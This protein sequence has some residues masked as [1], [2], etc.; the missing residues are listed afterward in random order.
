MPPTQ[1]PVDLPAYVGIARTAAEPKV[2]RLTHQRGWHVHTSCGLRINV[3]SILD[4]PKFTYEGI[5]G[6]D[7]EQPLMRACK[8][9]ARTPEPDTP[10]SMD[11]E[12][13]QP[14][15][16]PPF[17][18]HYMG[19]K[20]HG[21]PEKISGMAGL[22]DVLIPEAR[23]LAVI[24]VVAGKEKVSAYLSGFTGNDSRHP[25]WPHWIDGSHTLVLQST[26][27]GRLGYAVDAVTG[28]F[29]DGTPAP[30]L[31]IPE[32]MT[33]P[34]DGG[35][36]DM[37]SWLAQVSQHMFDEASTRK[38]EYVITR[39]YGSYADESTSPVAVVESK[40]VAKTMVRFLDHAYK[41]FEED[42]GIDDVRF[43]WKEAERLS[44]SPYFFSGGDLRLRLTDPRVEEVAEWAFGLTH[45]EDQ[46]ETAL[47]AYKESGY[48][49]AEGDSN[50]KE[51][52]PVQDF[53]RQA[54]EGSLAPEGY[55]KPAKDGMIAPGYITPES[56][57][58]IPRDATHIA[59]FEQDDFSK[60]YNA[61]S[62]TT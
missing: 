30:H 22:S 62:T 4:D 42:K 29:L 54:A 45:G 58:E 14:M 61:Q 57:H 31:S 60:V 59:W 24:G 21:L 51:M 37:A 19:L 44:S 1:L 7:S 18:I 52:I 36:Y 17:R 23:A 33:R 35:P 43:E 53:L 26:S 48:T 13:T 34:D 32:H 20:E 3:L 25:V 40:Q 9:C 28:F 10:I 11:T 6:L 41:V 55:G 12:S 27:M 39:T 8:N 47:K 15:S 46:P 5:E 50:F 38:K 2:H 56:L 16:E 49:M